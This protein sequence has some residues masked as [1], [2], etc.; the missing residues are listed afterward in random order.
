MNRGAEPK[1]TFDQYK[2][3]VRCHRIRTDTPTLSELARQWGVSTGTV[4][5]SVN[6]RIKRYDIRI[7]QEKA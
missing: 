7:Q 4:V 6:R 3:A 2:E 5:N 1:L